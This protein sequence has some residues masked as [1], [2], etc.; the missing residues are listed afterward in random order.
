MNSKTAAS[1]ASRAVQQRRPA[2]ILAIIAAAL[3]LKVSR[4]DRFVPNA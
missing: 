3:R 4:K 1:L 2:G